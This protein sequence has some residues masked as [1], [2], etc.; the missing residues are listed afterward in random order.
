MK[1]VRVSYP[2]KKVAA[3][4]QLPSSKSISN[5]TLILQAV[6]ENKIELE[7]ISTADDTLIMQKSVLQKSGTVNVKNAGTCMRFLTAYFSSMNCEIE[8]QCDERMKLRPIKILVDA[9]RDLGADISYLN[10]DG[11]PPLKLKGKQLDGGKI[12][13]DASVSSQFISALMLVAPTFKNGLEIEL[14]GEISSHSYIEMTKKLMQNFGFDCSFIENKIIIK[15]QPINQSTIQPITYSIE[16]DW[17]SASYWYEIVALCNDAEILLKNLS[18]KSLQGDCMINEYMKIFGVEAIETDEGICLRKF[19]CKDAKTQIEESSNHQIIKSINL[20]NSPDLAPTLAVTTAAKPVPL[21]GGKID[22]ELSGLKN[23]R[24]K[25]SDRLQALE[26]ELRKCG[27]DIE[28][29]ENSLF[30]HSTPNTKR[31]TSNIKFQTYNDHRLAMSFAPLALVFGNVIIENPDVVEK[32]Y[33][34]FWD[35]LKLAGFELEFNN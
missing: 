23:L 12:K 32:S 28:I 15:N 14:V 25:E 34:N 9:L 16:Q 21:S 31:Q 19:N 4:I 33:P 18:L 17:S 29:K 6:S 22:A 1:T 11:F 27:F 26:T 2:T 35:D 30:I 3:T 20:Q 10:E 24:I 13:M 8:L 5:R 7:N